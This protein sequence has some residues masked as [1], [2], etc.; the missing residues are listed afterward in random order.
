MS[1]TLRSGITAG[2]IDADGLGSFDIRDGELTVEEYATASALVSQYCVEWPGDDPGPGHSPGDE[3]GTES[4]DVEQA[5]PDEDDAPV[6]AGE[7]EEEC[8]VEMSSGDTCERPADDCPYHG[9]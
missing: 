8:G 7:D 4:D 1:Y 3:S 2:R 9:G 6:T 5:D